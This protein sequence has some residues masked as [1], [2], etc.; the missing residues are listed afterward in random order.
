MLK[1]MATI[2]LISFTLFS[3]ISTVSAKENTNLNTELTKEEKQI[4][5]E[6][7]AELREL[8]DQYPVE[9]NKKDKSS[10]QAA[11][12]Q[13]SGSIGSKGDILMALDSITDHVAIVKDSYTII[14][15]HPDTDDVAY[16]SNDFPA[17]YDDIKGLRVSTTYSKKSGAVSYAE[18][19]L[20]EPYTLFTTRN[21]TDSWYCSKLIWAAYM[22]QGIDLESTINAM[23]IT[24]GDLLESPHTSVFYQS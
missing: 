17:R 14:E 20:G 10:V 13:L 4:L 19:Q 16:R 22:S 9:I 24:P 23:M 18:R 7:R 21:S 11:S 5:K 3:G 1:K 2:G 12:A 6:Q 8:W 15:A